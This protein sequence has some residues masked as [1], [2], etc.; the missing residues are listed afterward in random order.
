MRYF[1]S[2]TQVINAKIDA[3]S[4]FLHKNESAVN[5]CELEVNDLAM[6]FDGTN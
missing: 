5:I 4:L 2:R 6:R 1:L 3:D